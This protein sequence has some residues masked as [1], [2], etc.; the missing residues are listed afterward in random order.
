[1]DLDRAVA[2][3]EEL[4]SSGADIIDVGGESTRPGSDPVPAEEQIRRTAPVVREIKKRWH[5]AVVSIDTTS[6]AVA[7]AAIDEGAAIINDISGFTFDPEMPKLAGECGCGCVVMHIKGTPKD[8]QKD[9]RYDDLWGEIKEYL[10]RGAKRL[11]DAGVS[12]ESIVV[13]PGIGFGKRLEHNLQILRELS[14]LD[15]LGFP[16]LVGPSRKSFI[17]ML[18]DLPLEERLEGTIAA[19][20]V[21]VLNGAS[22]VRVHDVREVRRALDVAWAIING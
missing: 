4:L 7:R 17:G 15:E 21:S 5:D 9:P 14:Q 10:A 20:V 18:L 6:S 16:I 12:G 8:M 2:R 22:I 13:D 3:A 19:C 11:L 1:F